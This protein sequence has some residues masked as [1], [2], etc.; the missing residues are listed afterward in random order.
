MALHESGQHKPVECAGSS[1]ISICVKLLIISLLVLFLNILYLFFLTGRTL[2]PPSWEAFEDKCYKVIETD[3]LSQTEANNLCTEHHATLVE[4]ESQSENNFVVGMVQ[5][6][7]D[8]DCYTWVGCDDRVT[9]GQWRCATNS[10]S[11]QNGAQ[12]DE[13]WSKL[14]CLF[15]CLSAETFFIHSLINMYEHK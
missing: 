6:A 11:W 7:C 13:F 2:C 14:E 8:G 5:G 3:P 10:H 15:V 4:I 12:H 9:E 1:S